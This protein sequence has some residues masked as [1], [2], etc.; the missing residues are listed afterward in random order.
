MIPYNLSKINKLDK[1]ASTDGNP[2]AYLVK[3]DRKRP[4]VFEFIY[5]PETIKWTD[6]AEYTQSNTAGTAVQTM[7]FYHGKNTVWTL[8]DLLFQV[9]H[10]DRV[11]E[12]EL[13][14]LRQLKYPEPGKRQPPVL[15]FSWGGK[16]LGPCVLTEI[17]VTEDY[18]RNGLASG[19]KMTITLTEIPKPDDR[20]D[21][22]PRSSE[23]LP[24]RL[25]ENQ[26]KSAKNPVESLMKSIKL[27][28]KKGF[29]ID[30]ETGAIKV[31]G[32]DIPIG[33]F[34]GKQVFGNKVPLNELPKRLQTIRKKL[35]KVE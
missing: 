20:L 15:Y 18:F 8:E 28:P 25:R 11:Y 31:P 30:P 33:I 1:L 2:I 14:K 22:K 13:G 19:G 10:H 7:Q 26:L 17:N 12:K 35:F 32:V 29:S 27:D 9:D 21:K 16:L 3:E 34:D 6:G 5:N 23:V 24:T 4:G